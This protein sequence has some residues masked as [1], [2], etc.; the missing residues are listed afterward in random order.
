MTQSRCFASCLVAIV[1]CVSPGLFAQ[2]Q[3]TLTFRVTTVQRS[4]QRYNPRHVFA[5]WV[6]DVDNHFVRTL[7]KRGSR[8][9][10]YLYT[11]R[12]NAGGDDTDAVTGATLSSHRTH[13]LSWD[14]RDSS[15][16]LVPDGEYRIRVEFTAA[17]E[18]GPLT[19]INLLRFTKGAE[20]FT[21]EPSDQTNFRDMHLE[22]RPDVETATLIAMRSTWRYNDAGIDLHDTDWKLVDFDDSEWSSGAGVLG[23]GDSP[24]TELE[25]GPDSDDKHPCYYFRHRFEAD[26]S[27][28]SVRLRALRDDGCVVYLNGAEVFRSNM[29]G[30]TIGFDTLADDTFGAPPA[31]AIRGVDEVHPQVE[32]LTNGRHGFRVIS[33]APEITSHHPTT[34]PNDG[35]LQI[36]VA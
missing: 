31:V 21:L 30:G 3:G 10:Q 34:Q 8:R 20:P 25:Y 16:E 5:A 4:G 7:E 22:Y 17:H 24:A 35:N 19:P 13:E 11:W 28:S 18:Q 36:A 6:T 33:P 2:T 14:G 1:T 12:D 32:C 29:P 27:P 26:W 9:E 23:Y 15:G